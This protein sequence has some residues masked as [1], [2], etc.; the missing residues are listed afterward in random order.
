MNK[1]GYLKYSDLAI[2]A[3]DAV[4]YSTN[5]TLQEGASLTDLKV[6]VSPY[7]FA[8]FEQDEY[9]TATPKKL[10]DLSTKLAF[11]TADVSDENGEFE[12]PITITAQF[13]GLF[14]MSGIT[15]ESR[16]VF[17]D[18]L[19]TAYRDNA[20][21]ASGTFSSAKNDDFFP[22]EIESANKIVFTIRKI[23]KPFHFVGIYNIEFGKIRIF[24]EQQNV[25][26]AIT[27]TFS[28]L[29]DSLEYD[30]LDL[31]IVNPESGDYLFQ[32]KQPIDFILDG[33]VEQTF[34]IDSG[35]DLNNFTSQVIAYDQ[36]ASLE[37][38]FYGGMCTNKTMT[39]L[40]D[41]VMANTGIDY[42]VE[43]DETL[44]TGYLPIC[45]K[46]QALQTILLTC[47]KRCYKG[48]KLIIGNIKSN[49][50]PIELNESN[51][52]EGMQK[53]KK[54][55]IRSLKLTET[56]Y[57]KSKEKVEVYHWYIAKNKEM[58]IEFSEPIQYST[59]KA[60]EVTGED[61]DGYDIVST[62]ES[63][64]VTFTRKG[65]NYC[66]LINTSSKKIV[67]IGK[68]YTTS[69]REYSIENAII[70]QNEIADDIE[71]T[72]T[73]STGNAQTVC[74]SLFDLYS[75]RKT[76]NFITLEKVEAGKMYSVMG[77]NMIVKSVKNTLNGLYEVE[78]V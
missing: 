68:K 33:N 21:I 27:Q 41:E 25:S 20:E 18:L 36:I 35:T 64:N 16:N 55:Q 70:S 6:G 15:I 30:T 73:L 66:K 48:K 29:G 39:S 26:P 3:K 51:I 19:V 9:V 60:Y 75:R 74:N 58:T 50:E 76:M 65:T 78:A 61:E 31:T 34:Y 10:Y 37:G 45:T 47:N 43:Q 7:D 12:T 67:L 42:E 40:I 72:T 62:A 1:Y 59:I 38:K 11:L 17:K 53:T 8:S 44:L 77:E 63:T 54:Q 22:L 46:R 69:N 57:T 32:R 28:V 23:D 52:A 14:T 49:A 24:D 56:N 13:S 71:L 2:G 4:T 5:A